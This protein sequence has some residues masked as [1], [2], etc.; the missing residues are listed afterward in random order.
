MKLFPLSQH[1][2]QLA[3]RP[4]SPRPPTLPRMHAVG[5]RPHVNAYRVSFEPGARTA[6]HTHSGPQLLLV[7]EGRCRLQK[8]GEPVREVEAG[9]V[10]CIEPGERHWHGASADVPMTHVALNLDAA[11]TWMEKVS[12]EEYAGTAGS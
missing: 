5:G 10:V 9:S 8:A 6:W 2:P 7:V 1:T 12:D 11:T 3:A 4:N